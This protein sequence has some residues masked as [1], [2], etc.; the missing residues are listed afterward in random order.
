MTT[1]AGMTADLEAAKALVKHGKAVISAED[2]IVVELA[3]KL[4]EEGRTATLYLKD[5]VFRDVL[6][7][8][9][10]TQEGAA[11][12]NL[13]PIATEEATQIKDSFGLEL[14]GWSSKETCPRC[15]SVYGTYQF[16]QQGIKEHGE[17]AV[18]AVFSLDGVS[19]L[20][21]HPRQNT[22]CQT[23]GLDLT[24]RG[25][26]VQPVTAAARPPLHTVVVITPHGYE[27]RSANHGYAC[28]R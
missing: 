24:A 23:C 13:E 20:Q 17:A 21:T 16:I 5:D 22:I 10:A 2:S 25:H 11:K 6:Q 9:Y 27:Y 8:R 1:A 28:C 12:L 18:R 14:D 4:I 19:V 26:P 15:E 7:R 3:L